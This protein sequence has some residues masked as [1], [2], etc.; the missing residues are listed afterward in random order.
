MG[1]MRGRTYTSPERL[2]A[3]LLLGGIVA[4]FAWAIAARAGVAGMWLDELSHRCGFAGKPLAEL[5]R[6]PVSLSYLLTK[7]CDTLHWSDFSSRVPVVLGSL[8]IVLGTY[9]TVAQCGSRYIGV[10][11]AWVMLWHPNYTAIALQNRF[12]SLGAGM[13]LCAWAA[14]VR[15]ARCGTRA[16]LLWYA[17]VAFV[18]MHAW[19]WGA[20]WVAGTSGLLAYLLLWH[21]WRRA[22]TQ[23]NWW[24]VVNNVIVAG[25]PVVLFALQYLA[26][27]GEVQSVAKSGNDGF[28]RE[29]Q[30]FGARYV[31]DTLRAVLTQMS[32]VSG[33]YLLA[34]FMASTM[35]VLMLQPVPMGVFALLTYATW[36]VAVHLCNEANV[37][38]I[39]RRIVF[40]QINIVV[41]WW[42]GWSV[43][44][45]RVAAWPG[46][47]RVRRRRGLYWLLHALA[48]CVLAAV[49][50]QYGWDRMIVTRGAQALDHGPSHRAWGAV[51]RRHALP[52]ARVITL[53]DGNGLAWGIT[54]YTLQPQPQPALEHDVRYVQFSRLPDAAEL[55]RLAAAHTQVWIMSAS[56]RLAH[57]TRVELERSGV[58][59]P[60]EY[61]LWWY[62][63]AMAAWDA[64]Q[65]AAHVRAVLTDLAHD[66]PP[67]D[68]SM[69]AVTNLLA[70]CS[71]AD[72]WQHLRLLLVR[73]IGDKDDAFAFATLLS[74]HGLHAAAIRAACSPLYFRS[75]HTSMYEWIAGRLLELAARV[76]EDARAAYLAAAQHC[77]RA[78]VRRGSPTAGP[79]L[80][81][82]LTKQ[83]VSAARL[84]APEGP[85]LRGVR[86]AL[87]HTY[88]DDRAAYTTNVLTLDRAA[89]LTAIAIVRSTS[90]QDLQ[91]PLGQGYGSSSS[92][93]PWFLVLAPSQNHA[94]FAIQ[95]AGE[96][97]TRVGY[98]WQPEWNEAWLC[99]AGVYDAARRRVRL[100]VNGTCL[101]D[102]AA[103]AGA[104]RIT[105]G[106]PLG[107]GAL[108]NG[109][110]PLHG[111]LREA[112]VYGRAL[113]V[114]ELQRLVRPLLRSVEQQRA[115]P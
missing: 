5:L 2:T 96:G 25:A 73:R 50:L 66:V 18:T 54:A 101:A 36:G 33:D 37:V 14:A 72:L 52:G 82:T 69:H 8:L 83:H 86:G 75:R 43:L 31:W 56:G 35:L 22:R 63:P 23:R 40:T 9:W 104:P 10:L 108:S 34:L 90:A 12:Y 7:F 24:R 87:W 71:D 20:P 29:P 11:A 32:S 60:F 109:A 110:Y 3:L 48:A 88:Q 49:M 16:A 42:A 62:E 106:L 65:R 74:A 39:P 114:R 44:A 41:L 76:P 102:V 57:D 97:E 112:A 30:V 115:L 70:R 45:G 105:L 51:M 55:V 47:Q 95:F 13:M 77:L 85:V 27:S 61:D 79:T 59:F 98:P 81:Q 107:V 68:I 53:E 26:M 15:A 58:R 38:P 80:Q 93:S 67:L 100:Y 6:Y 19:P 89:S 103:P 78:A 21:E 113:S 4:A 28:W 99:V 111:T 92:N 1:D 46:W 91:I 84:H 94:G 64:T 17:A